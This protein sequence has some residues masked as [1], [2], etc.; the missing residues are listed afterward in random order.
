V[1]GDCL[2]R[3]GLRSRGADSVDLAVLVRAV[4][5]S[6]AKPVGMRTGK[7]NGTLVEA[8][9]DT[10][11]QPGMEVGCCRSAAKAI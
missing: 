9:C 7:V 6:G 11:R 4:A 2:V 1:F 3:G 10:L 8:G 5:E